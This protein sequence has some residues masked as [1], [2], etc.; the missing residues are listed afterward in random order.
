MAKLQELLEKRASLANQ[1]RELLDSAERENRELTQEDTAQFERLMADVDRIKESVDREERMGR[2]ETDMESRTNV[3]SKPQPNQKDTFNQDE[4]RKAFK[5][6]AQYGF[7]GL[8]GEQRALMAEARAQSAIS[9]SAGGFTVPEGFYNQLIGAMK[10]F[11]GVREAGPTVLSTASG[12]NLPIPTV[13]DTSNVGAILAENATAAQQDVS[14]GQKTLGAYKYTSK[15]ILVPFELM[16]DSAF[17]M[18][19]FLAAKLAER[20][21]RITNTHFTIG[22]GTGQPQGVVTGATQG[23][24]GP[25]GQATAI[26]Y[27]NLIDLQHSVNRVYRQNAKFMLND[28]TLKVIR[29]LKDSDGN[30]LWQPSIQLGNPD[31]VLGFSY[32]INDDIAEMAANAKSILFGDFSN[33]FVRDVQAV[34]LYRIVDKYIESGQVGFVAFSRH[35][36]ALIDAGGNP[37]KYYQNSAT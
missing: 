17:D 9:G 2:L 4:Y 26:T 34:E 19:A 3:F 35:D 15:V 16:Q 31:R 1:A 7:D 24:V 5:S 8:T 25:T 18:E 29:K 27:E 33:Y 13:D 20:I 10:A 6:W 23:V 21:G 28:K 37:I 11:G 14:F 22:T 12:N 30:F 36:G 32:I